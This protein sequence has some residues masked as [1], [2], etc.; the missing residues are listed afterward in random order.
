MIPTQIFIASTYTYDVI[1]HAGLMFGFACWAKIVFGEKQKRS[2]ILIVVS[3]FVL[4]LASLSK[5]VYVP[6]VLLCCLIPKEKFSSERQFRLF[7]GIVL[8]G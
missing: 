1:V 8:L 5:A 4:L 7:W 3:I 6:L 2:S